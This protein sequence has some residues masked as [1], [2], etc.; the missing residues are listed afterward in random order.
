MHEN[1]N[2]VVAG[3]EA[4]PLLGVIP[5]DLAGRHEQDLTSIR[6]LAPAAGAD[7]LCR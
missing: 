5:L 3:E 7:Q 2:P 6:K 4:E 1:L